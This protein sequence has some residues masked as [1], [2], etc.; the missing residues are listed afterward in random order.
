MADAKTP[1]TPALVYKDVL[2]AFRA[3]VAKMSKGEMKVAPLV[4]LHEI[5]SAVEILDP[6]TDS[7]AGYETVKGYDDLVKAGD[8]LTPAQLK[9]LTEDDLHGTFETM[10]ALLSRWLQG[11]SLPQTVFTLV[12]MHKLETLKESPVLHAYS[13]GILKFVSL[14]LDV[15]SRG[16][17][18][19]EDEF[20]IY[21]F[22][23]N[24]HHEDNIEDVVQALGAAA[25]SLKSPSVAA[26][27][28]FL[29]H[30]IEGHKFLDTG[31]AG[32]ATAAVQYAEAQK[33]LTVMES[34]ALK[35]PPTATS[36]KLFNET[37]L[38]WVPTLTPIPAL[39]GYSFAEAVKTFTK[40]IKDTIEICTALPRID[41]NLADL[42]SFIT[43]FSSL[44]PSLLVR[45]RLMV[46]AYNS[47]NGVI[48]EKDT[49][50]QLLLNMLTDT[51][52]CPTIK[53]LCEGD[54]AT[55]TSVTQFRIH[56]M[57]ELRKFRPEVKIPPESEF[58]TFAKLTQHQVSDFIGKFGQAVLHTM[59]CVLN[60]RARYRR[61][62]SNLFSDYGTLQ[63]MAWEI[64]SNV[65]GGGIRCLE[66]LFRGPSSTMDSC[67]QCRAASQAI[68][69][70][71]L[72]LDVAVRCMADFIM[73]G[74]ELQLYAHEETGYL[75]NYMEHILAWF[76]ENFQVLYKVQDIQSRSMMN[77]KLQHLF[78]PIVMAR[79]LCYPTVSATLRAEV[80][81]L[82]V[83][84]IL[85]L[86]L[87]LKRL[88]IL[89]STATRSL[90]TLKTKFEHRFTP[91]QYLVRPAQ[92][93][94][95]QVERAE[96]QLAGPSEDNNDGLESVTVQ[97]FAKALQRLDALRSEITCGS[98]LEMCQNWAGVCK[99]NQVCLKLAT[100][101]VKS[102]QIADWTVL[103][104]T[105][106][107]T[108]F[109]TYKLVRKTVLAK[110]QQ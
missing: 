27:L 75:L 20:P 25:K 91:F 33:E 43:D 69:L 51:Y 29:A 66:H 97:F 78:P 101:L 13:R 67:D 26:H 39:T 64:D 94:Y 63:Q 17:V 89:A 6:R 16:D 98:T 72:V 5:I 28:K 21:T 76:T 106:P 34:S 56:R 92:L 54:A 18:R 40:I 85:R 3:V 11:R 19:E 23:F 79:K 35:V 60:N 7:N 102:K 12:H 107:D 86:H 59:Y 57:K 109:P 105:A 104:E 65:F 50:A 84:A 68:V 9:G 48:L 61:R 32:L 1:D 41:A 24:L 2:P 96:I 87:Y 38:R 77:K 47:S 46:L 55:R 99:A 100:T 71:A 83:G 74:F 93:P 36:Q 10:T 15:I 22:N 90:I 49:I 31:V 88:G 52:G 81:R 44:S 82:M 4:Q 95:E 8:V 53:G 103:V 45:S 62:L 80:M 70:S 42:M 73:V 37:T 108:Y 14:G 30:M 110:Q 58:E